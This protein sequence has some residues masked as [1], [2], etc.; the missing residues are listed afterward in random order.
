MQDVNWDDIL[1]YI[2][3]TKQLPSRNAVINA[4]VELTRK[5]ELPDD[6]FVEILGHLDILGKSIKH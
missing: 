6:V 2:K 1:K 4:V 3:K 5:I